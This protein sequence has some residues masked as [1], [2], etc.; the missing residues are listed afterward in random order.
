MDGHHFS[1]SIKE[2]GIGTEQS[3]NMADDL[4][5]SMNAFVPDRVLLVTLD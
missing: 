4:S 5:F 3:I 2:A 1:G